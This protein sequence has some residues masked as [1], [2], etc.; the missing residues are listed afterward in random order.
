VS[1]RIHLLVAISVLI[2]NVPRFSNEWEVCDG[3]SACIF[4]SQ[5]DQPS[6]KL[7]VGFT[8]ME[9]G[10]VRVPA[11]LTSFHDLRQ[12][13]F[14]QGARGYDE[15]LRARF[16]NLQDTIFTSPTKRYED[17]GFSRDVGHA[18]ANFETLVR[19]GLIEEHAANGQEWVTFDY[20]GQ[21]ARSNFAPLVFRCARH[22]V[23][24]N[25]TLPQVS[26][27]P[28]LRHRGGRLT[29]ESRCQQIL[30]VCGRHCICQVEAV[31]QG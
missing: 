4:V 17:V 26:H 28:R 20:T 11:L 14:R 9:L 1:P 23:R 7:V 12:S 10:Y 5:S 6:R 25:P 21:R 24:N 31:G 8:V 2:K 3:F 27:N 29:S 16:D 15:E 19:R 18:L 22:L 30:P 13:R